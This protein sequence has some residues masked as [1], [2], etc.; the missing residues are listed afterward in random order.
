M[1]IGIIVMNEILKVF[2]IIMMR[3]FFYEIYGCIICF[4]VWLMDVLDVK[5]RFFF[6]GWLFVI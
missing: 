6:N 1:V 5:V 3:K 2:V 4:N